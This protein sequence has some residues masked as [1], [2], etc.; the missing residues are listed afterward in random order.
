MSDRS[1]KT[2]EQEGTIAKWQ[3][4]GTIQ[5]VN[6][7][8]DPEF[9]QRYKDFVTAKDQATVE[10]GDVMDHA[11]KLIEENKDKL[12]GWYAVAKEHP[13]EFYN[14]VAGL[15]FG[16]NS[17]GSESNVPGNEKSARE[18]F[19]DDIVDLA[20]VMYPESGI[21]VKAS[22]VKYWLDAADKDGG[23]TD[24]Q[25]ID[26]L[27]SILKG[28]SGGEEGSPK[29]IEE[30]K[31]ALQKAIETLNKLKEGGPNATTEGQGAQQK[32]N[33][34]SGEQEHTRTGAPREE[35][36][37][38]R[39][40][41]G[42]SGTDGTGKIAPED[43]ITVSEMLDKKG[44]Y[45]GQRG[46]FTQDGQ[47]VIFKV[48]NS[49]REYE[50]GNINEVG[51][52]GIHEFGID[53]E[54]SVVDTNEAGNIVV[55]GKE[56]LNKYS[57]PLAAINY[58]K[59]GNLVSV[60][61]DTPDGEKRTFRGP[62][63]E[64][65]AYQITLK[66]ISNEQP[67]FEDFINS[68]EDARKEMDDAGLSA[69]AEEKTTDDDET[70][71]RIKI[72]PETV[73]ISLPIKTES[74]EKAKEAEKTENV[75][76]KE[77]SDKQNSMKGQPPTPPSPPVPPR[78]PN[79]SPKEEFTA[80][81]K[82]KNAEIK[83]AKELFERQKVVKW[84]ETY[85]SALAN[86]QAM[87]PDKG[88][89][90]AIKSRVNEFLAKWD[91][92]ELFNPTSED[93]AVFNV[94]KNETMRRMNEIPGWDSN[95]NIQRMA[96]VAEFTVLQNDLLNVAKVTNP[97][98]EAGRA[99]NLLQSEIAQDPDYGLQIRR[100]ELLGAKGGGKLTQEDLDFTADNWQKERA[101]I[102]R[103]NEL[104]QQGLQDKFDN[105]LAKVKSDY[106]KRLKEAKAAKKP[107][108]KEK[109]EKL[110][111]EKGAELAAKIRAGKLKGTYATFPGVPQ[112]INLVLEGIAQLVEKGSTLAEAISEYI[113]SNNIKNRDKFQNDLFEVFNKQE[114]QED[115]Y[116]K[117]KKLAE[118]TGTTDV[119]NDMVGKNLIRDYINSHVGLHDPKDVLDIAHASLKEIL[120][121]LDKDRLREAYL[122]QGE[123]KQP[124]KK[125]LESGFKQSQ[126]NFERLTAIEKDIADLKQKGD[127][128]KKSSNK[129]SPYDKDIEAK[130]KEKKT[131]MDSIGI[132]T[133]AEDKYKKGSYDQRAKSHNDR[134]DAISS[135]IQDK[136]DKVNLSDKTQKSLIK[137]KNQLDAAK[138]TLDPTSALSQER[139]LDGGLALFKSIK[140]EFQRTTS[141]DI[142]KIGDINRG[143]QR[144]VDGFGKDKDESE[145]D[146]KLQR[147]K[148]K[149]KR[150]LEM[151]S[152]KI[153]TG[154]Y[155]DAPIVEL[156]KTDAELIK[157]ERQRGAL[158]QLYRDRQE[159]YNKA[160]KPWRIKVGQFLR[161]AE[162]FWLLKSPVTAAK[163]LFSGLTK[164]TFEAITKLTFGKGFEALPLETTKAIS[165]RAKLGGESQ[166]L[167]SIAKSYE[168]QFR[169]IGEEKLKKKVE[170]ANERYEKSNTEYVDQQNE[171]NRLKYIGMDKPE[172]K[173]AVKKLADLKNKRDSDLID[174][175][176]NSMYQYISG[177]SLKEAWEVFLHRSA[178]IERQFGDFGTEGWKKL[179]R[180]TALDN[181]EYLMNFTG[182]S[183]AALKNFSA[184]AEFASG[185][186]ARLEGAVRDG[187][188]ISKP[189]KILEI[190]HE[191]YLNWDRGK[192]QESNWV[193]DT[194]GKWTRATEK[195]SPELAFLM[196][197]DVAITRV[198][199]NM[200]RE[201]VME[202]SI[203]AIRGS[204]MAAREYY[205]AKNIVLKDGYTPENEEAFKTELR[206]QLNKIDPQRAATILRAFRKGGFGLG[207]YAL[208][209]TGYISFGGFA[210]KGQTAEDKKKALREQ[211]TGVPEIK[212]SEIQLGDYKLPLW[213]SQ[214]I[215]HTSAFQPA[216]F[217]TGLAQV[218][219]NNIIDGK[220]TTEA[221][222]ASIY[223]HLD[224]MVGSIP[225]AELIG[226][227]TA[228]IV[229]KVK[230]SGQWDD[231]DQDGNPMKRKSFHISDYL[232]YLPGYGNK[233]DI[234]SEA[235]YKEAVKAQT[236][237][238]NAITEVETNTSLSK[239][240][241]EDQRRAL[242]KELDETIDEIYKENKENPQ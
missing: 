20:K 66:Q 44:T 165:E 79:E 17:D 50:L 117:I 2:L 180:S 30:A 77:G 211:D 71:P 212:T 53:Q 177:S 89:Y 158:S 9:A 185:F 41:S 150:D 36:T 220:T 133:S 234:L 226:A 175:I 129:A 128:F 164:P 7:S 31:P 171:V 54:K 225:Q 111:S 15:V 186:I 239:Q 116:D 142:S 231:V 37:Q 6:K 73:T 135:A 219:H 140:S 154:E 88:L 203:G 122:K 232:N 23:E 121:S 169:N 179:D 174:A 3:K 217:A 40:N 80:V 104:K 63:G 163:V 95:D 14:S 213:V 110:L 184:R 61:L 197:A 10:G 159:E 118:S 82:E 105:E 181:L 139:T 33:Q 207:M 83:G 235:Y 130:E 152:R 206:E 74:D 230:P 125:E 137:L 188:D 93:I 102:E 127:L 98:G 170:E 115:S 57:D 19:G 38:P 68:D 29:L 144:I 62:I 27:T 65:I 131:I 51:Q 199:V 124:T 216:L 138:I 194:W 55:R 109:R 126:K 233:K 227:M 32:S 97:K 147:A 208:A 45:K 214:V 215:E 1:F 64:D 90:E 224:H 43:N 21:K 103:E 237:Y 28:D 86:V 205:K 108:E 12:G 52:R 22:D 119:T 69:P 221:A 70:V 35:E 39:T 84:T 16:R 24:Q 5:S 187:V 34:P 60:T 96:A 145:Q 201:A 149:A 78:V 204:V 114:Q 59:D 240:D 193:S 48:D 67:A 176:G 236:D 101:L 172:Y 107:S 202:Y 81:R 190:A 161:A 191:S 99:F 148:D 58:D 136:I 196:K 76:D 26:F 209:A 75:E 173:E 72:E 183:H 195:I 46:T 182:R 42:N 8:D 166:S 229:S 189:E 168:A 87:Y 146:I 92:G 25:K 228:G 49:N 134:V 141:D 113:K 112:A 218:Y 153:S 157:L 241:K 210:H 155:E 56:Y 120:P 106:E 100:M 222:A 132:K 238:R 4:D 162:V 223:A 151:F 94:F 160:A 200:I 167:K 242:L 11:E 143:L 198:P 156:S 192:Y 18:Q 91:A 13:D 178:T 85:D 123:F 47:A